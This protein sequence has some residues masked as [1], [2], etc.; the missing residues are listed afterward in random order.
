M[1]LRLLTTFCLQLLLTGWLFAANNQDYN[2]GWEAFSN[3]NRTAARSHFEV[4]VTN[5][6]ANKAEALLSLCLLDWS[7]GKEQSA[8]NYFQRFYYESAHPYE[9]LEAC[10]LLPFLYG[11]K[12]LD[13]SQ[14]KFYESI[15]NDPK[16]NGTLRATLCQHLGN[17]YQACNNR[18]KSEELYNKIGAI[19]RW[20]MLGT[21]DNISSSGFTKDWGAVTKNQ[22]GQLFKNKEEAE[23]TWFTPSAERPDRWF[24]F[25]YY[26]QLDNVILYAQT[27]L[28]SPTEQ[29]VIMR[30]GTSGSLKVWM[31]D[32]KVMSIPEEHNCGMDIYACKVKLN[33]GTNRILIQIGQSEINNANFLL[34]LTDKN[35]NPIP[36]LSNTPDYTAYTK[37]PAAAQPELIPFFAEDFFEKQLQQYPGNMLN[38]LILAE[39]YLKNDKS[40]EATKILKQAEAKAPQSSYI[41]Y[42]LAE[43]Y[44]R[45]DN[46][47]DHSM[48]MENIKLQDPTSFYAL[49]Q[50][51]NEAMQSEKYS[52][53]EAIN[54]QMKNLYGENILTETWDL[55]LASAQRRINDV[56]AINKA[57]YKKY[58]HIYELMSSNYAILKNIQ[59]DNKAATALLEDYIKKYYNSRAIETL[60]DSYMEQGKTAKS[61]KIWKQLVNEQPHALG[62]LYSYASLLNKSQR[63]K[64]ALEII[65]RLKKLNPYLSGIYSMEGYIYIGMGSSQ[66]ARTAF[67]KSI[68]Y[69]PRSYD[70]RSQLRMLEDKKEITELF[71]KYNIDSIIMNAPKAADYPSDHSVILLDDNQLVYYPEGAQEH[72][73]QILV[74]VLNQAGIDTWKE[75]NIYY[76]NQRLLL[77]KYEVIKS[78]GKKVRAETD[79]RG[80]VVFTNIEVGDVLHIEYRL[81]DYTSGIFSKHFFGQNLFQISV[82][83]INSR[84]CILAP[85]DKHFDYIVT[86]GQVEPLITDLEDMKLYQWLSTPQ[87]AIKY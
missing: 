28:N 55:G 20:Q 57:L 87:P 86:N 41:Q 27:F 82:P 79:N 56:I 78:N 49:Q 47:T 45:A 17:H 36:G 53:A 13:A 81:Q 39:L 18:K 44:L 8:F 35:A 10:F 40:Y 84:Y 11:S 74:K 34:R 52:E 22:P 3:N 12:V 64:E 26:F 23:I 83:M 5:E 33:K 85:A 9:Y 30:V 54:K 42:R 46:E 31:N 29:E 37:A 16:M 62:L 14:L 66:Q 60:S 63:Y 21:F 76:Q 38:Y 19:S 70:S 6:P 15:V 4:A 25:D 2:K 80:T 73:C 68:Y 59:K 58:P 69:N 48:A 71:P 61:L 51:F 50:F 67:R 65:D 43:A 72:R 75:Y 24:D 32:V 7:E 1:K 77:D